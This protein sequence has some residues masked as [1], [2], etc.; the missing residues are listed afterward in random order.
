MSRV[1]LIKTSEFDAT[2]V[3]WKLTADLYASAEASPYLHLKRVWVSPAIISSEINAEL[4]ST[5]IE[6]FLDD[7][8]FGGT[9]VRTIL[10]SEVGGYTTKKAL[11]K[12]LLNVY[13]TAD[14][15]ENHSA[16]I[17]Y[18]LYVDDSI[19]QYFGNHELLR[20]AEESMTAVI[21]S[22]N[23]EYKQD[24]T[25][26]KLFLP[27]NAHIVNTYPKRVVQGDSLVLDAVAGD[28]IRFKV[29]GGS[30]TY[31]ISTVSGLVSVEGLSIRVVKNTA[32]EAVITITDTENSTSTSEITI[33]VIEV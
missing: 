31:E 28:R 6:G 17:G 16:R 12:E 8:D 26:S 9:Y 24:V 19:I 5:N 33:K 21:K 23:D 20:I 15:L 1:T 7:E 30:G 2:T 27:I 22:H 14:T 4:T 10:P 29:L 18:K 13:T 11:A 25:D 3:E 32:G